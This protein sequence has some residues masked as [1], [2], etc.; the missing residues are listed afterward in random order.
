MAQPTEEV[1][2]E[3]TLLSLLKQIKTKGSTPALRQSVLSESKGIVVVNG[4][5]VPRAAQYLKREGFHVQTVKDSIAGN[6]CVYVQINNETIL[7]YCDESLAGI[8][9][10][11]WLEFRLQ[12]AGTFLLW[13]DRVVTKYFG[14]YFS[15]RK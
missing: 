12:K 7:L 3:W 6:V 10:G 1:S 2:V 15:K 4:G 14:K 9:A 13:L 11:R 5:I 8:W